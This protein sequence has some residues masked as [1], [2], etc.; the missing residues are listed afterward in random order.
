MLV[1]GCITSL[2]NGKVESPVCACGSQVTGKTRRSL[3]PTLPIHRWPDA[4]DT[5]APEK[6][7]IT[8]ICVENCIS[9]KGKPTDA[10]L[11][12]PAESS[13]DGRRMHGT[14]QLPMG[15]RR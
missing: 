14:S 8:T 4:L 12:E 9:K 1:N 10:G 11:A 2:A 13:V 3:G 7:G 6:I 5:L 15:G